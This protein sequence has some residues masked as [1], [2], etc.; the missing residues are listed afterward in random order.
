MMAYIELA[1]AIYMGGIT[2]FLDASGIWSKLLL[3]APFPV[4]AAA[5]FADAINRLGGV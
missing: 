1:A 2:A 5:L 3:K 4:I